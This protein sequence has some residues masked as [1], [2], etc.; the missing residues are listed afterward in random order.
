LNDLSRSFYAR[1]TVEVAA[2]L[3][4]KLLVSTIGGVTTSGVILETEAYTPDDP[5]SHSFRGPTLRNRS[6]FGPPGHLYVYRIYGIHSCANVVTEPEH[7]GAAVLLRAIQPIDGIGV[8]ASRRGIADPKRFANGPG[9]L[10]QALGINRTHD[11][12]DLLQRGSLVRIADS[13]H[14]V[15]SIRATPRIGISKAVDRM[16]RFIA[17]GS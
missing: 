10:G 8:I 12:L 4:G 2:D 6:M 15:R 11:G 5:A 7:T 1:P 9:K 13:G 3:I 16:W 14:R 17:D